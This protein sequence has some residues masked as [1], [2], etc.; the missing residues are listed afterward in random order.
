MMPKTTY[1]DKLKQHLVSGCYRRSSGTT[2][3]IPA[4]TIHG[5]QLRGQLVRIDSTHGMASAYYDMTLSRR[6][7]F[8]HSTLFLS[9]MVFDDRRKHLGLLGQRNC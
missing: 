2:F 8:R 5:T 4:R 7:L 1:P 6:R 9:V 3:S